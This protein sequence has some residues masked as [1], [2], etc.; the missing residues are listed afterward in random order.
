MLQDRRGAPKRPKAMSTR[1]DIP[2]QAELG[3]IIGL[4]RSSVSKIF[5]GAARPSVPV[6]IKLAQALG[7]SVDRLLRSLPNSG[8]APR[9]PRGPQRKRPTGKYDE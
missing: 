8:L 7:I 3:R 4:D 9:N 6:M 1:K 2:S 5:T